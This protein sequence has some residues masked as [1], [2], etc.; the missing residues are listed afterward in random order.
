MAETTQ[1]AFRAGLHTRID[2]A[3]KRARKL[4]GPEFEDNPEQTKFALEEAR[5]LAMLDVAEAI[6][7]DQAEA[8]G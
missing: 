1:D 6:R 2:R 5:I 8:E 7:A 3:M 4:A